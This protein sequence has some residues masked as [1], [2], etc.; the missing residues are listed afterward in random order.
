MW[1]GRTP[2]HPRYIYWAV[3]LAICAYALW[4]GQRDERIVAGICF[5]AS[6]ASF[7]SLEPW[8]VRYSDVEYRLLLV[9]VVTLGSFVAVALHSKRFWPLW[10]A[11][12]QLTT[13]MG[14]VLK[15]L[16]T[17]LIPV[18]Y[19]AALRMWAY[20]ILII[21]AVGTWRSHRRS[22]KAF[23]AHAAT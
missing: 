14:H 7:L 6:V 18:A 21:L 10:V 23:E 4:R 8:H 1:S 16:D 11:G 20:P 17:D 9:D 12:L 2:M 19:G 13:S 5:V 3:L 15:A 22:R